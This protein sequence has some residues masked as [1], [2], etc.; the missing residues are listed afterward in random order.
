MIRFRCPQCGKSLKVSEEKAGRSLACPR[1]GEPC[2]ASADAST[3]VGDA[4]PPA[5]VESEPAPGLFASMSGRVRWAALVA[6]G[7]AALGLLMMI[8]LPLVPGVGAAPSW[9]LPVTLCSFLLLAAILYGHG[10]GCPACG[11]WWSRIRVETEFVGR[12]VLDNAEVP[13]GRSQ[14]R[15]TYSCGGC[16]HRWT[17]METEE[18]RAP[19]RRPSQRTGR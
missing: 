11:R 15:T 7:V 1:C 2:V 13:L 4:G 19:V 14:Y 12:E 6:A 8:V 3:P 9:A 5:A 16:S 18:Y 10:T 17:V